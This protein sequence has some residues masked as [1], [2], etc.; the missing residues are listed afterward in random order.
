[1]VNGDSFVADKPRAWS[2]TRIANTGL[3]GKAYS[4]APDGKRIAA[5]MSLETPE[6][7]QAQNHVMFVENLFD[8]L[9]RRVPVG[10]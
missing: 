10:N 4:L 9:M 5:L 2:A 7:Q 3:N 6:A 1:M 8:E